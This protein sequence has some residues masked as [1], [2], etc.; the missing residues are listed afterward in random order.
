MHDA[1]NVLVGFAKVTRDLTERKQAEEERARLLDLERAARAHAELALDRLRSIQ[2]VTEAAL[3]HLSLDDLLRELLERIGEILL[4]DS[5]T[6]LLMDPAG[7]RLIPKAISGIPIDLRTASLDIGIP[8]G[9]GILGQ[10]AADQRGVVFEDVSIAAQSDPLLRLTGLSSIIRAPLT[11]ERRTLGVLVVG[12]QFHRHFIQADLDFLQIVADRVAM[13]IDRARLYD[14]AQT[15]RRDATEASQAVRLRDEFLSVA[16]HELRNPVAAVKGAAQ[17]LRRAALR[18]SLDQE[19]VDRYVGMIEQT[20]NRL[21]TLTD[22]LLDVSR[23]QQGALPLRARQ[24]DL[25]EMIE[26]TVERFREQS[27]SHQIVLDLL[28]APCMAII[29]PDRIEQVVENLLSNAI[30]YTPGGGD[31]RVTLMPTDAGIE[32]CIRDPGIGLPAGT[33]DRIFEPF[34]RAP[35][36]I[37]GNIEGLGLGLYIC[38][39]IVEQ[40]GGHLQAESEGEGRGTAMRVW[41]PIEARVSDDETRAAS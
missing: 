3:A 1:N 30:K 17:M 19:R 15:A 5:V 26:N 41:L 28:C 32:L 38:R 35:N 39:K 20:A 40:H 23:L 34:G 7:E 9:H 12:T 36:A 4:V 22:D 6:V 24:A 37:Q 33:L 31:I 11:V 29:D 21:A 27:P 18:G 16:S 14:A 2:N 8:L 25:A 13:A 10:I